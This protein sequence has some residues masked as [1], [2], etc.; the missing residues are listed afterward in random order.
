MMEL[1]PRATPA[2]S[3][4]QTDNGYRL[5]IPDGNKSA[6]R[7]AQ[8]D[9]YSTRPRSGFLWTA[10]A[11]LSLEARVSEST[12]PGTWGFGLWNDPFS[13]SFGLGGM[14]RRL[15]ALP[16]AA[17]FFFASSENYLSFRNDKPA[18]G[19]IAQ[20]FSAPRIP[21]LLLAPGAAALPFLMWR[22]TSRLLRQM[23]RQFIRE[24]SA[25]LSVDATQWHAYQLEWSLK[26]VAFRVDE[27]LVLETNF[28]PR[29]PLGL[30][31]WIDNQFAAWTPAGKLRAGM[32]ANPLAWLEI[33]N[34][35]VIARRA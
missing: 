30:V 4:T 1:R 20:T 35:H 6:Y 18:S 34:H 9:D 3:V 2:A 10:P 22:P 27:A 28:S 12:L 13:V 14:A 33:K 25:R 17:W 7:L 26:R 19:F 29:G 16:N 21:S 32:L 23:A 5:Q 11:T 31:I 15:P 24:D 8:L